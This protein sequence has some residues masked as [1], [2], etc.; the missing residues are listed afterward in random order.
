MNNDLMR[1]IVVAEG[2]VQLSQVPMPA[3]GHEQ[4]LVKVAACTVNRA[5]LHVAAGHKHGASGGAGAVIGIEWAGEIAAI[6]AGV[7]P[8][9]KVGDRVMCSGT[10]AYAEYAVA[11]F[12][13][14][15][16]LPSASMGFAQA[17][18][19]PV[20]LQ[21]SHEALTAS[22]ALRAGQSVLVQGASSAVGLMTMQVAR[23]LGAG[24]VIGT[25]TDAERRGRLK[26]YGAH[27]AV[28]SRE[29][30]WVDEVLAA[31]GGAGVD[32]TI[33]FV[34]GALMNP[35]MRATK[36]LGRIVNVGRMGGFKGEFDF[37]LHSLRRIQYIG[38]TFRTRSIDEVRAIAAR[39]K[40]DLWDAL[41]QGAL[42]MP[43]ARTFRL[44]DAAQALSFVAA[45]R[46]FGKVALEI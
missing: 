43:I 30:G 14:V 15:Y 20:A 21:T 18:A 24:Q 26:D 17:S 9:F 19:L 44:E 3:C 39:M 4:V 25:S 7:P 36:V 31:T 8:D 22:G 42:S 10:G 13:R 28:N 35:N 32:L 23:H 11:D 33:D 37:D 46:H 1:A 6:G 5:D 16:K 27:L 40:A 12:G 45:N 41:A 29:D 2:G 38:A 34:A